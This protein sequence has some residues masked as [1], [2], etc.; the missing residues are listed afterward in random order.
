M[1]RSL[2]KIP[3]RRPTVG[4]LAGWQVYAGTLNTFLSRMLEGVSAAASL[5]DC[6]LLI[7]CGLEQP[8]IPTLRPAWPTVSPEHDFVPVGPWNTSGLIVITPLSEHDPKS[9]YIQQ[10]IEAGHPVVF[11]GVGR[12]AASISLDNSG[13]IRQALDHLWQHG[14][15]RIAFVAGLEGQSGDS[16]ERLRAFLDT[17]RRRRLAVDPG[18]IAYGQF[19]LPGGQAAMRRILASRAPFTAVVCANDE[20]AIGAMGALKEAGLR[21]PQDVAVIGFDN[22]FEAQLQTPPL[23]TVHQP[24]YDIGYRA[25]E[26]LLDRVAGRARWDRS[27]YVPATLVVR[28]SCGCAPGAAVDAAV[29]LPPGQRRPESR[30]LIHA[31]TGAV[32]SESRLLSAAEIERHCRAWIN[33][34]RHSAKSGLPAAF[35]SAVTATM[36]EIGSANDDAYGWQAAVSI[37]RKV[38]PDLAPAATASRAD[39]NAWLDEARVTISECAQRQHALLLASQTDYTLQISLLTARLTEATTELQALD[40]LSEH[41]P[42]IG[43]RHGRVFFF[44]P[45]Q[46]D[47]VAWSAPGARDG[48]RFPTRAFPPAGAYPADEAFQ[49]ALLPLLVDG[50]ARGYVAF[51][52]ANL[53]PCAAITR[54]LASALRSARLRLEAEDGRRLAEEATRLKSRFLSTVSHELRTPLSIIVGASEQLSGVRAPERRAHATR[55]QASALHLG[56]LIQDVLDLASSEAGA[57]RLTRE[58]IDLTQAVRGVSDV[59]AQLAREKGLGWRVDLQPD[60]PTVYGDRTRIQQVMLNLIA[61]AVKFTDHGRVWVEV[62]GSDDA[63][64]VRVSDTGLGIPPAEREAIFDEFHQS[65]RTAGGGFGGLGLGLAICRRLIE[66]HGGRI[67]VEGSADE[68]GGATFWFVLPATRET[69]PALDRA[70][71]PSAPRRVSVLIADDEPAILERHARIATSL[72]EPCVVSRART[73]LDALR[74][75]REAQPDLLLLDLVMPELDGFGVIEAMRADAALRD[76]PVVVMTAQ[77]LTER[78]MT[79]LGNVAAVIEKG[80]LSA[81]EIRD[82]FE[83]VLA[84]NPRLGTESHRLARR[85]M[86]FVHERHAEPLTLDRIARHVGASK[87]H[88]TRCVREETGVTPMTYLNRYRVLRAQA[89]LDTGDKSITEIALAIGFGDSN[90]FGRAFKRELGLTPGAYRRGGGRKPEPS[91]S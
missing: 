49:L 33:G 85:A 58:R 22:R 15:R 4:V 60:L 53:G 55:I 50:V 52:A 12:G 16:Q 28:E 46:E 11:A 17:M 14:H 59:G 87:G 19:T 76:T 24:I 83:A 26:L 69:D 75:M 34:L 18:L 5:R 77:P 27:V 31:M 35:E 25:L 82:R 13:G 51:D 44:E 79:R 48:P 47:P 84:R 1:P 43:V 66:L 30:G 74:R 54:Q 45:G 86:A 9:A 78:D 21:M 7:A 38:W 10:V 63:V 56:H 37:L 62:T 42:G 73:G 67:G 80:V 29:A 88:V 6:N 32:L 20:S 8:L 3:A 91:S 61:N 68:G 64:T 36:R 65:E 23:T 89:M 72:S 70:A 2:A 71:R 81:Q 41:L 39:V 57:L 40:I 90:Y